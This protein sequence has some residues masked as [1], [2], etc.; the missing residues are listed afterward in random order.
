MGYGLYQR[1]KMLAAQGE[2]K[3]QDRMQ[4]LQEIRDLDSDQE[5]DYLWRGPGTRGAFRIGLARVFNKDWWRRL[6]VV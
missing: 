3:G 4:L 2:G 5:P 1:K 6:W